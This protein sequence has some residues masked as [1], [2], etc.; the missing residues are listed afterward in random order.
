MAGL[1]G[2][3]PVCERFAKYIIKSSRSMLRRCDCSALPEHELGLRKEF[4][5]VRVWVCS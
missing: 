1:P 5:G 3:N 4:F 2:T